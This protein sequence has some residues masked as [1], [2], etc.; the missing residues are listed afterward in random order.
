MNERR[1]PMTFPD[2]E[3]T[4][5]VALNDPQHTVALAGILGWLCTP[6]ETYEWELNPL[7]ITLTRLPDLG[8]TSWTLRDPDTEYSGVASTS[9][10]IGSV[11]ASLVALA[12]EARM[13]NR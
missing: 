8:L 12:R 7:H 5:L 1:L 9:N 10:L 2:S 13:A 11:R 4:L 6:D 3:I